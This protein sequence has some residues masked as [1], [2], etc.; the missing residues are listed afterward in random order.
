[1]NGE[2]NLRERINRLE[3]KLRLASKVLENMREGVLIFDEEG[4]IRAVNR[5]F[6]EITGLTHD[7]LYARDVFSLDINGV[8]SQPSG[9]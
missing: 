5:A 8:G 6:L 9:R 1:M 3:G 4:N 7:L 2:D